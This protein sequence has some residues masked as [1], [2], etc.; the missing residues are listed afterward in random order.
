MSAPIIPLPGDGGSGGGTGSSDPEVPQVRNYQKFMA[1][2]FSILD[3]NDVAAN[4]TNLYHAL[5]SFP[6]DTNTG[7]HLQIM[8]YGTNTAL[9]QANH[10]DYSAETRD[11]ALLVCDSVDKP[12]WKSIDL[13]GASDAQDGWLVQGN[14]PNWKVADPM[15]LVVSGINPAYS[16]FFRAVPYSGPQLQ[17]LGAQP[18]DSVSNTISL[19]AVITDLSGVT[20]VQFQLDISGDSPRYS[21]G[22]NNIISID[23]RYQNNL[24]ESVDLT[25]MSPAR[26]YDLSN[27]PAN[28]RLVFS[29]STT[30]PLEFQNDTYVAFSAD[31]AS[32]D[33]GINHILFG[34]SKAQSIQA[35]ISHPSG[36]LVALYSGYMPSAGVIDL[37]W[38]F[39]ES[40]GI[41]PYS[42]DTYIVTFTA[43]DPT[44]LVLTNYIDRQG[45][46][47]AAGNII[48]Y[49]DEDPAL[50]GGTYLNS[51]AQNY[52]GTL[53]VLYTSL[54]AWNFPP[55]TGYYISDIGPNRDNPLAAAF[56][57]VLGHDN[58]TNWSLLVYSALTNTMFSD[59]GYYQG[60]GNGSGLGGCPQGS[61]WQLGYIDTTSVRTFT[62]FPRPNWRMRKVALW[63]CY[64]STPA[65]T[66]AGGTFSTWPAAFGIRGTLTQLTKG[67]WKNVGLFFDDEIPDGG[68]SGT[69]GGTVSEVALNF[70]YLWVAGPTPW[71]GA[72]DPTYSFG[73]VLRQIEGMSPE[74]D[75][76][77]PSWI[78][79]GYLPYTGVLDSQILTNNIAGIHGRP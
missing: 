13:H 73:W 36:P 41:T 79:F 77:K 51:Q 76:G 52:A 14:V 70:D 69:T 66:T 54:Y 9:I 35:S 67:M 42:D 2:S 1:Q 50:T 37:D 15:Y 39:T 17:L 20:N 5:I 45:V 3:T 60:H 72:C 43:L 30:L 59:F 78:G 40:D 28:Q 7:P 57:W 71:P 8:R 31:M 47:A 63:A 62:T 27:P 38:N 11:F 65:S 53:A 4:D 49:E 48:T 75:R 29:T 34:V 33:V 10:F 22:S 32:P 55:Y 25:I 58:L 44:T 18:Y 26:V 74:I 19:Q 46:R 56:P 23:T 68:I 16:A 24:D 64:S 21:L 12:L 61:T 6:A